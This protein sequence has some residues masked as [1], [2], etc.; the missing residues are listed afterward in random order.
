MDGASH[1]EQPEAK[2]LAGLTGLWRPCG[3]TGCPPGL[4]RRKKTGGS[5]HRSSVFQIKRERSS[6]SLDFAGLQA[7]RADID[8]LACTVN[9]SGD[10]LDIR[11]PHMIG[12]SVGM[13]NVVSEMSTF[14]ADLTLSHPEHLLIKLH[15]HV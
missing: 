4:W 6:A 10:A 12:S 11:L 9:L 8:L 7:L 1:R 13:G 15:P 5:I 3:R 2:L 14:T